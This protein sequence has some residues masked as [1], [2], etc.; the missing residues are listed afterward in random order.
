MDTAGACVASSGREDAALVE[1]EAASS[2]GQCW[3]NGFKAVSYFVLFQ[4]EVSVVLEANNYAMLNEGLMEGGNTQTG[5]CGAGRASLVDSC[6]GMDFMEDT[7]PVLMHM[8]PREAD[9]RSEKGP[10]ARD[11]VAS[12][13]LYVGEV[14]TSMHVGDVNRSEGKGWVGSKGRLDVVA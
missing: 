2:W 7:I 3:S 5:K 10:H 8:L 12:L 1:F 9:P 11:A 13:F 4:Q 14:H 6:C